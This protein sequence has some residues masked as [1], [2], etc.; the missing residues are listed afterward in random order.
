MF[1]AFDIILLSLIFLEGY[2]NRN[3]KTFMEFFPVMDEIQRILKIDLPQ[4]GLIQ[5]AFFLQVSLCY[6]EELFC[7]INCL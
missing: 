2:F 1:Q 5:E 7:F 6:D 3:S 4:D